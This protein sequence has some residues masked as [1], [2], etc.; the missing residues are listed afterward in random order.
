M[1]MYARMYAVNKVNGYIRRQYPLDPIK[2]NTRRHDIFLCRDW[3]S[4]WCDGLSGGWA[5]QVSSY[6]AVL[7]K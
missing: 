4:L 6:V 2:W 7:E 1:Y 5:G 3:R